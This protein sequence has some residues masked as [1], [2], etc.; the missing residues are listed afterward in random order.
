[1]YP[2]DDTHKKPPETIM[3]Q[4]TDAPLI[5]Y[6]P[7]GWKNHSIDEAIDVEVI[8][9]SHPDNFLTVLKVLIAGAI[10]SY[11][12]FGYMIYQIVRV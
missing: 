3:P 1:M 11:A 8:D 4:S 7:N 5:C 6:Y 9:A 2:N 10:I 12:I